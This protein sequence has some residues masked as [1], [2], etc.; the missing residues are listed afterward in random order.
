M[1]ISV[2]L[3]VKREFPW[4]I[5]WHVGGCGGGLLMAYRNDSLIY[6]ASLTPPLLVSYIK[7]IFLLI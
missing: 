7:Y 5:L 1:V 3:E 2:A 6:F 4:C